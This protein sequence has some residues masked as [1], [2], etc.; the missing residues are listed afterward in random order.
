VIHH[1]EQNSIN[2]ISF[3]Q[4]EYNYNQ[5]DVGIFA[6]PT[7]TDIDEDGLLDMIIGQFDGKLYHYEQIT[8]HA[9]SF[10]FVTDQFLTLELDRRTSPII[11]DLDSD[12]LIDLIIGTGSG[13][14]VHYE[15]E[16]LASYSFILITDSINVDIPSGDSNPSITDLDSDGLLDLI[17]GCNSGRLVSFEQETIGSNN[18]T[19]TSE[20]LIQL[21]NYIYGGSHPCI[22]DIDGD[23]LKDLLVGEMDGLYYHFEQTEIDSV[24]FDLRS[25]N[26]LRLMDVGSGAAPCISDFDDDGLIDM[27]VGEWH[28]N[29]NHFEQSSSGSLE[30]ILISDSLGGESICDYSYPSLTDL[31]NDGLLDLIMGE[32]DGTLDHFEQDSDNLDNFNLIEENYNNIDI[33]RYASPFLIDVDGDNTLE[34]FLGENT[35]KIFVYEQ[36]TLNSEIFDLII[37]SLD[38]S[39]N[40]GDPAPYLIDYDDDGLLDLFVGRTTGQIEHFEQN[41]VH[42]FNFNLITENFHDI[43]VRKRARI[44]FSDVNNDG[45]KDLIIGDQDGGL[46]LYLYQSSTDIERAIFNEFPRNYSISQ[47]YPNPFNPC[48]TIRYSIPKQSNV[49]LKLYDVLGSEVATLVNKEQSRGNY[50]VEF[51]GSELGSGIYF[52]RLQAGDFVETRKMILLK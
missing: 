13:N 52:N 37:D 20:D 19:L 18:F 10:V 40:K 2:S 44:A 41:E 17:V 32:R 47:N 5:I 1:F 16:T 33:E 3:S 51:D 43:R 30:F 6:V 4:V 45:M 28:G 35:G 21:D 39:A 12:N 9:D 15:Q 7:I 48:T 29:L 8:E 27:I 34:M 49:A 31:D 22:Y 11:T 23:G 14:L 24:K 42:S 38:I 26:F 46:R 50:E 25:S 36:Q